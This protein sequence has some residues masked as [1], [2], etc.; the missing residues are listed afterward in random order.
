MRFQ[1]CA[2]GWLPRQRPRLAYGCD[3][4]GVG[5]E[6]NIGILSAHFGYMPIGIV[7]QYA[8]SKKLRNMFQR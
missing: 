2:R 5:M 8:F 7:G 3:L 6:T 1:C 4:D